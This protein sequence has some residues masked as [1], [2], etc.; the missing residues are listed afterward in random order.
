[1]REPVAERV[2]FWRQKSVSALKKNK[3]I[4][5]VLVPV[6]MVA[7]L[8]L[9]L[10][11][12]LQSDKDYVYE[13]VPT[14]ITVH[15]VELT[16]QD[17]FLTYAGIVQPETIEQTTPTVVAVVDELLVQEVDTVVKGQVLARLD[18]EDAQ[19][20]V[21][22]TKSVMDSAATARDNAASTL[23][24]AKDNYN[25]VSEP[26]DPADIADARADLADSEGRRD[27]KQAEYDAVDAQY[28]ADTAYEEGIRAKYNAV[29][30]YEQKKAAYYLAPESTEEEK[31]AK[32]GKNE[33]GTLKDASA[34]AADSL[35]GAYYTSRDAAIAACGVADEASLPTAASLRSDLM[36]AQA[37]SASSLNKRSSAAAELE[38]LNA[39]VEADRLTLERLEEQGSESG[40]ADAAKAALESAQAAYDEADIAYKNAKSS[41]DR[42]KAVLNDYEIKAGQDGF[43]MMVVATEGATA[44]PLAPVAVIGSHSFVVNFG[45]SQGDAHS[46]SV[47]EKATVTVNGVDFP[48]EI[49]SV[50][51]MPDEVS[52]TY[53]TNVAVD[54]SSESLLIGETATVRINVGEKKGAWLPISMVLNDG[55]DY[56]FVVV[57]SRVQRRTVTLT[58]LSNDYVL[59][60]GLSAGDLVVDEGL[61][62]VRAGS[63]VEIAG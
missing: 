31:A 49:L 62:L 23:Q 5:A 63:L 17:S 48:G 43:V 47:G 33:D 18:N 39:E 12:L 16:G 15:E 20:A 27:S 29:A 2:R 30:D 42:A 59:V 19:T 22:S 55:E 44:T 36:D 61:S 52:R 37:I 10:V 13:E 40:D 60:E 24:R 3:K 46:L 38:S 21:D 56:V 14:L 34:P 7:A 41:Y 1:M 58:E 8:V 9:A 53:S 4:I 45:V 51:T 25:K 57:D 54:L 6:I 32:Y 11:P 50:G 26:A 35:C 28:K